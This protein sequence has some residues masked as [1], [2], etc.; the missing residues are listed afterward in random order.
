MPGHELNIF[1]VV[2]HQFVVV[3]IFLQLCIFFFLRFCIFFLWL[4][5]LVLRLCFCS[6]VSSF[7]SCIFYSQL[8]I[9]FAVV[10]SCLWLCFKICC[11]V[12]DFAVVFSFCDHNWH[13]RATVLTPYYDITVSK[14]CHDILSNI[15]I[16]H[17][18]DLLPSP[19]FNSV[20]PCVT[21][22][23][24]FASLFFANESLYTCW[25]KK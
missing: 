19:S 9:C 11:W 14:I 4:C 1:V 7:C 15:M 10:F 13:F 17:N 8:C 12:L 25:N 23:Y 22:Y 21:P 2:S 20:S 5:F 6:C 18:N 16:W 3:S 24:M